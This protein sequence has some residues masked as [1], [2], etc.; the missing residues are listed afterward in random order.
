MEAAAKPWKPLVVFFVQWHLVPPLPATKC[1]LHCALSWKC[2]RCLRCCGRRLQRPPAAAAGR[3]TPFL[4]SPPV[5][6]HGGSAMGECRLWQ[7]APPVCPRSAPSA[8]SA[9]LTTA[10]DEDLRLLLRSSLPPPGNGSAKLRRVKRGAR[11]LG[12]FDRL[13]DVTSAIPA[14][15]RAAACNGGQVGIV[16]QDPPGLAEKEVPRGIPQSKRAAFEHHLE[17]ALPGFACMPA[18][19]LQLWDLPALAVVRPF[20]IELPALPQNVQQKFHAIPDQLPAFLPGSL[21][22]LF[23]R[24]VSLGEILHAAPFGARRAGPAPGKFFGAG[25]TA[26][27]SQKRSSGLPIETRLQ[28]QALGAGP[29][30]QDSGGQLRVRRA[31]QLPKTKSFGGS[32]GRS[33]VALGR[34]AGR[35]IAAGIPG[36]RKRRRWRRGR[37]TRSAAGARKRSRAA[38]IAVGFGTAGI[39]PDWR[40]AA[41]VWAWPA[42]L[43]IAAKAGRAAGSC[44][45]LRLGKAVAGAASESRAAGTGCGSGSRRIPPAIRRASWIL[46]RGAFRKGMLGSAALRIRAGHRGKQ[47]ARPDGFGGGAGA[48]KKIVKGPPANFWNPISNSLEGCCPNPP[49][50]IQI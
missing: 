30:L 22:L 39:R 11:G 44:A 31:T 40:S 28:G 23:L 3:Q 37:C 13:V 12:A 29:G 33:G 47:G 17:N 19:A 24:H 45:S 35:R 15:T 49:L 43:G 10:A 2:A 8:E 18:E 14:Q 25:Q 32:P 50:R 4:Q 21:Q 1:P 34:I 6:R 41:F 7:P 16:G 46:P 20:V 48:E 42:V 38:R 5:G 26:P 36:G 27:G 9:V